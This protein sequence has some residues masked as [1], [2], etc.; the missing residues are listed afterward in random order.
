LV[1]LVVALLGTGCARQAMIGAQLSAV[2]DAAARTGT[3]HDF[4]IAKGAAPAGL[5]QLEALYALA[6]DDTD[7]LYLLTKGWAGATFAF[8]FDEYEEAVARRDDDRAEY[9]LRRVVAGFQRAKFFGR[10]L[11]EERADGFA[12]AAKN[13]DSLEAW[14]KSEFTDESDAEELLWVAFAWLSHALVAGEDPAALADAFVGYELLR[15]AMA[16]DESVGQ[17]IGHM[18]LGAYYAR[19]VGGDLPLA[20]KHFDRA[21]AITHGRYLT[22]KLLLATRYYCAA[23]DRARFDRTLEEIA[24]AGDVMPEARIQ[25][26]IAMRRARRYLEHPVF[27]R[28]CTF[29]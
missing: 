28:T 7:G 3:M 16:L 20:K 27:L 11:L 8:T 1:V 24:T 26:L 4:E 23:G 21:L 5:G 9:E 2:R 17:G 14:L 6:P 15:H 25:N 18:V 12:R 22:P 29:S 13:G 10:R 19:P